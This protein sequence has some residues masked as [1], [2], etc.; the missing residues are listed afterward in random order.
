MK[1]PVQR[2][3]FPLV[4]LV[5]CTSH[6]A[7]PVP[8][9]PDYFPLKRGL[10][11]VYSVD[12]VVTSQNV[13]TTYTYDLKVEV[14]DSFPNS[15]G[16]YTYVMIRSMRPDSTQSWNTIDS[17]SARVDR[18]KAVVNEGNV[19]FVKLAGP[20]EKNKSWNG[21][22]LNDLGGTEKCL[23]G[24]ANTC[25]IYTITEMGTPIAPYDNTLTVTQNNNE[26][27]IVASDVRV[28]V[29]AKGV[30]LIKRQL[31]Q[32]EY[33]NTDPDCVGTQ[34]VTKGVEYDQNLLEYGGL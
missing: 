18:Y 26:D 7:V 21:N 6:D 2:L 4:L 11:M 15:D 30:G 1:A 23:T 13:K 14:T 24:S 9:V 27:L 20:L 8:V 31:S 12:S 32:L 19:P 5:G 28:E 25:D 17:W 10:Y 29:Y 33:C 3:L 34:F 16:G 22:E